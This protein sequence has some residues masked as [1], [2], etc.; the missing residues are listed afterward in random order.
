MNWESPHPKFLFLIIS[1][2]LGSIK[3]PGSSMLPS[4]RLNHRSLTLYSAETVSQ[5]PGDYV[6]GGSPLLTIFYIYSE[7]NSVTLISRCYRLWIAESKII[8]IT[9]IPAGVPNI[10]VLSKLVNGCI[11]SL[12]K[13]YNDWGVVNNR[14]SKRI[15]VSNVK[16]EDKSAGPDEV[17]GW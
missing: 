12:K 8:T 1:I 7:P 17:I 11:G 3:V 5:C 13:K 10:P 15:A 9:I 6:R 4:V 16:S 2:S 14:C